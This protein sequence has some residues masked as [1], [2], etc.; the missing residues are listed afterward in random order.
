MISRHQRMMGIE[1]SAEWRDKLNSPDIVVAQRTF[2]A[3]NFLSSQGESSYTIPNAFMW[4]CLPSDTP[5]ITFHA[6]RTLHI[7]DSLG[8]RG[9][10]SR[11]LHSRHRGGNDLLRTLH[12]RWVF[13]YLSLIHESTVFYSS[14]FTVREVVG[15][16][17]HPQVATSPSE[18]AT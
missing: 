10:F 4:V 18:H 17:V 7:R 2:W 14:Y 11:V 15:H 12:S 3:F 6:P 5:Y 9:G 1:C 13:F 8:G 16:L